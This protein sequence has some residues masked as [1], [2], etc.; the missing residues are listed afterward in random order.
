MWDSIGTVAIALSIMATWALGAFVV[1]GL[2]FVWAT[3]VA[4]RL[5]RKWMTAAL[6]RDALEDYR[7]RYP[8]RFEKAGTE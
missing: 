4:M 7:A 3:D 1:I 6:I 5:H 2:L 8:E